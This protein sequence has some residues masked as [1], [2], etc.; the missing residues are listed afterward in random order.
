MLAGVGCGNLSIAN[1]YPYNTDG[2]NTE[3]GPPYNIT[4]LTGYKAS[5]SNGTVTC[6]NSGNWTDFSCNG[7]S[8]M[9]IRYC[10]LF[11]VLQS[12]ARRLEFHVMW[13]MVRSATFIYK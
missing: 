2:N 4:C 11:T 6:E 12:Q 3:N 10:N 1:A 13:L 8:L 5:R 9:P 7:K